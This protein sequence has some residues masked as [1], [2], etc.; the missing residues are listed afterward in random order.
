MG[1][2]TNT[3]ADGARSHYVRPHVMAPSAVVAFSKGY[4][5]ATLPALPE[6][7]DIQRA[8]VPDPFGVDT[9]V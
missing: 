5:Q 4:V 3:P 8:I 7:S 9:A 2:A 1:K 6:K